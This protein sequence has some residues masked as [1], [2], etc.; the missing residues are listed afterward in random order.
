MVK[1]LLLEEL[2]LAGVVVVRAEEGVVFAEGLAPAKREVGKAG[3]A[4]GSTS[5]R[6]TSGWSHKRRKGVVCASL[7]EG[8]SHFE[9]DLESW[10]TNA[11]GEGVT[12]RIGN[13]A[14]ILRAEAT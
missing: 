2:P 6:N 7:S 4:I 14:G 12:G 10:G 11:G 8:A 1:V 13:K 3:W 5:E 9:A